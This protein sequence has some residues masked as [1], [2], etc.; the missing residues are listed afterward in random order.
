MATLSRSASEAK[1]KRKL[2]LVTIR[3]DYGTEAADLAQVLSRTVTGEVRFDPA[4]RSLY[5]S[6]LSIYR[7]LPVGVVIP[8]DTDDVIAT[9]AACRERGVP[10]LGRGCGT[11]L[12]GQCCNVAVVIDFSKYMNHIREINLQNRTA[13]V[14][15]GVICDDLRHAANKFGLTFPVDPATHQYCT[16][17]GMI[18]N[19]SC[20]VHSVMGGKTVDNV[21]E[22]EILTYGGLRTNVG[23]MDASQFQQ[24]IRAG[25][26]QAEIYSHLRV[27]RDRYANEVRQ[28]YPKIPRR[29][30]GYNLDELLPENGFHVAR[31]LVGSEGT[32]VLVLSARVRLMHNLPKR[33]LLVVGY[34]DLGTAG[35][36]VPEILHFKPIGLEGFH[37]HVIENMHAKGK[38]AAAAHML[39]EGNVWL[40]IE[41]GG[42]T[43]K[44]ANGQAEAV[45]R[46]LRKLPG[47]RETKV[48]EKE[49]EQDAL[50][51]ARE[52]GVG[53]S[54]VPGQEEAWPSWE[55]TAVAPEKL[56]SY[57]REFSDLVTKK[58]NYRWTVFGHFGQGCIHT[59]ITFDLK[60]VE[61]VAKFRRF[62]EEGADLVVRYGGSI[63][64]EHGD[65]QA[66]G[67]LLPKMFGPKLIQAFR[68]FKSAWD[69]NWKMNPGKLVD[70]NRLDENI[71]VGP[72]YRPRPV[73]THF[74]FPEDKGSLA[75]ATERC[76]GVGKCRSL[77]GDTMCP[78]F[79]A[80]REEKHSTRGRA[81]L[82][83]EMLRGDGI[84]DG[85][86]DEGVKEAL[87]L[88]L[89]C[90]GC[91]GD[92][93]V[94]VDL[95]T[96][97][98]EFLSHYWENKP[99]PRQA[100]A[101]GLIDVWAKLAS[102]AP[103]LANFVTQTPGLS[104]LAKIAAGM[105]LQRR[106]PA[107]API[108][109]QQW[110][111][112]RQ[113]QNQAG[114]RIVLW[115]DTFN[116]YF[117]PDIARAA[118]EVLESAGFRVDVPARPVCCGRPL[119][120]FGML[121]RAKNY[122]HQV[123]RTL[124]KEI[125]WGIP[126]VVLEP[127]CAA[128]FRDEL[129]NLLAHD[130]D[131]QRLSKQIFLLSEFLEKFAPHF[132]IPQLQPER[133]ALIHGHCHQKAIMQ[134]EPEAAI[135]KKMG[136]EAQVLDSGCCGMAG[137]FGFEKEKYHVSVK[138]GEHVLLPAVRDASPDTLIVADGFSCQEQIEQLTDRRALHLA[139]V[140][141][142]A[143]R[144]NGSDSQSRE[145]PE[146]AFIQA[147]EA[148][149]RASALKAGAGLGVILAAGA[150]V[151]WAQTRRDS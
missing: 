13:W 19:N 47:N 111:E 46:H 126:I 136:I 36:H 79:R 115:P 81:H 53:A 117:H 122:L 35:D 86:K 138:C 132:S 9:V 128:V 57:L 58:F 70:A 83:F 22:L 142:M 52:S 129:K 34:P 54:R 110:F 97:K 105:P 113:T 26:H 3:Q 7:Q 84:M 45:I 75:L 60:T 32:L 120:D 141:Q 66:R 91:K 20:G 93:P 80:T 134:M 11:S 33:A 127:S 4:S 89:A 90:K 72:E 51:H 23:K 112:R 149:I 146:R 24:I 85:W 101:L 102:F 14:E 48:F 71:R 77:Q 114:R 133:K 62:M 131:A 29:V 116:N 69:P 104:K 16:L 107:F 59:R 38:K 99:R 88:C 49:E 109:F 43:Q 124:R 30:S 96:Y 73:F 119:Y 144:Q 17:G 55:D 82:L 143:L 28:R 10:I 67:E 100:Y 41:F 6:D 63:S 150:A 18:G 39:P 148:A 125:L 121:D 135:M 103:G 65:G 1:H 92:C 61:G 37:K 140:M 108:T 94:S 151:V 42:E 25:G 123:I 145:Y 95:A 118:V 76:F 137:S 74:Q 15:P 64:G 50:W 44:D 106:I 78:S 12:A 8:R 21:E 40:L 87:D 27:L 31:S 2:Q 56:G 5:A 130:E 98:A 68:E 139:Q 147:R